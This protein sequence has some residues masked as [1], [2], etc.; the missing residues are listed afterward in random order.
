MVGQ[1]KH[2]IIIESLVNERLTG[3]EIYDDCVRRRIDL[4]DKPMTHNYYS[5][6]TKEELIE[7]LKYYQ[8]NATYMTGGILI[9][10]E[11]HG[12]NK[13]DGLI[14]SNGTLIEWSELI[15]LF[16]PINLITCNKLFV[17]MATCYGRHLY[18]GVD[19]TQK[20][21]YS[22]Y[23]SA[24][25]AVNPIEIVEK[26]SFLF[27]KLIEYGNL[28][29]AYLEMEKTESNFYYKDSEA[30]FKE[31]YQSFYDNQANNPEFRAKFNLE[32][33]KQAEQLGRPFNEEMADYFFE[34]S[35]KE[36]YAK[37]KEAFD[38]SDCE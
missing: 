22:G 8:I 14:L 35:L 2:I 23:I 10:L 30:T 13:L 17:T 3:K 24:S 9:H 12:S 1:V 15:E 6:S 25:I 11:M 4:Y 7:L 37:Q 33:K 34:K 19:P 21:P 36:I 26:Y 38:F 16:R 20:S 28:V 18:K 32:T 29:A 27:E 5:V 31:A